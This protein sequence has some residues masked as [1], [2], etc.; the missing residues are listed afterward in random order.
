MFTVNGATKIGTKEFYRI[1]DLS[2]ERE[3]LDFLANPVAL[4]A[5]KDLA[6][7]I[8]DLLNAKPVKAKCPHDC[9]EKVLG[10]YERE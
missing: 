8:V 7:R 2:A 9:T 5:D 1:D 6:R 10:G 3:G 4:V